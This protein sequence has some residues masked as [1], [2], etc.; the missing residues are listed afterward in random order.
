MPRAGHRAA[1]SIPRADS[2]MPTTILITGAH[3]FL[4]RS[5]VSQAPPHWRMVGLLRP[6]GGAASPGDERLEHRYDALDALHE[7]GLAPDAVLHL[8]ACIPR[9]MRQ[10]DPR[11]LADNVELP[12]CLVRRYPRARHVLAS[13]IS[14]YA[15]STVLPVSIETPA[16]PTTPYGWS[17]LAA[18][19]VA[20]MADRHAVLRL[21]SIIGPGMREGSF[22]PSAVAAAKAGRVTLHGDGSRLQ[23]YIDVRDAARMCIAAVERTDNFVTLG[24]SGRSQ[25]NADVAAILARLT[26]AGIGFAGMD[27]SPSFTCTLAGAVELGPCAHALDETLAGMVTG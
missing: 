11:L 18:E 26:G 22:I 9:D 27:H 3:G 8:A 19:S 17:K 12:A 23:D 15:A 2:S 1:A 4:A 24:V 14:V 13:S 16:Q 5:I 21:S 10:L 25:S 7:S 20:R 6:G